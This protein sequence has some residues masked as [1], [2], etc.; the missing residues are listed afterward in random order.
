MRHVRDRL[1]P[2]ALLPALALLTGCAALGEVLQPPVFEMAASRSSE[3]R[4]VGP[5]IT[6]PLG[7]AE[8]RVWTRV[9]NPNPVGFTL[10][11]LAGTVLLSDQPAADVDLPLGLPLEAGQDTVVPIAVTLSFAD[12][13]DI[14]DRLR[15]ALSRGVIDYAL[16][17]TVAVDA[18]ALGQP[19][20]GPSTWVRGD[21]QV[22]R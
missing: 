19:V 17:G 15:D 9:E 22:L 7:G 6:R 11:R 16:R 18:G 21:V 1:A 2:L 14:A 12:V 5:S 8:I 13:P 20:F 4:L 10:S 3:I